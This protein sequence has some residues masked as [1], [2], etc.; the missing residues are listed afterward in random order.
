MRINIVFIRM[1]DTQ[2]QVAKTLLSYDYSVRIKTLMPWSIVQ[3]AMVEFL[4]PFLERTHQKSTRFQ[5][6]QD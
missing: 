3:R 4:Q 6:D 2:G 5:E 1:V